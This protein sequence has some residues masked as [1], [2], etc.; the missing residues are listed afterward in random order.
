MW[1]IQ[2]RMKDNELSAHVY[3]ALWAVQWIARTAG[4][5][6]LSALQKLWENVLESA[7]D[8]PKPL[9]PSPPSSTDGP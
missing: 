8:L 4:C 1:N 5:L 7:K 3:G 6:H 9:A 2:K